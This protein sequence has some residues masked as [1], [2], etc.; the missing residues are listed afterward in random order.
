MTTPADLLAA[1]GRAIAGDAT[2]DERRA[3]RQACVTLAA[4]L[5][6]P[7]EP[8]AFSN[9]TPAPRPAPRMDP[10][11]LLMVRMRAFLTEQAQREKDAAAAAGPEPQAATAPP[12]PPPAP[13]RNAPATASS[14]TS[15]PSLVCHHPPRIPMVRALPR[16]TA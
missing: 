15:S 7:G 11:D 13:P 5:G 16:R 1:I 14:R 10:L 6:E 8:M 3:G 9:A 2:L 12:A 4:A